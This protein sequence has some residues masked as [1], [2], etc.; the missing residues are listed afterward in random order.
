[1]AYKYNLSYNFTVHRV[2]D[3]EI[4]RPIIPTFLRY[5]DNPPI[6]CTMILDSGADLSYI[7]KDVGDAL[8][9]DTDIEASSTTSGTSGTVEVIN[10]KIKIKIGMGTRNEFE[11]MI[12][13]QITKKR[14]F[15]IIP[16][17]GREP[18][19]KEFDIHFRMGLPENKRKFVLSKL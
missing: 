2:N 4:L 1:M 9:I 6:Y 18:I 12:P 10:E 11:A 14:E 13:I 19:F 3:K 5:K 7:S 15:P 8:G 16:A 17:L